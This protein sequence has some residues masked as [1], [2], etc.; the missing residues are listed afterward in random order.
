MTSPYDLQ[1][2]T[3]QQ[4][5]VESESKRLAQWQLPCFSQ[6]RSA[7]INRATPTSNDEATQLQEQAERRAL[8]QQQM[9]RYK[10]QAN[11]TRGGMIHTLS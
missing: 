3:Q 9:A 11:A 7:L 10:T 2:R 8:A 1:H 5:R 4:W 6:A